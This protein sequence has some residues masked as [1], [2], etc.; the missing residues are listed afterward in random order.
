MQWDG[1]QEWKIVVLQSSSQKGEYLHVAYVTRAND[2][3]ILL[4]H[5]SGSRY[6]E[7]QLLLRDILFR[8]ASQAE[9][10]LTN[11]PGH[12]HIYLAIRAL[13]DWFLA[14]ICLLSRVPRSYLDCD[15]MRRIPPAVGPL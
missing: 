5:R 4:A 6:N 7:F 9:S 11:E 13:R 3:N 8:H 1:K 14:Y 10:D 15:I 12:I 2:E